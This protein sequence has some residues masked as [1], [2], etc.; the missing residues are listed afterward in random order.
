MSSTANDDAQTDR[1]SETDRRLN[2][3][4]V[5]RQ[6]VLRFVLAVLPV[7]ATAAALCMPLPNIWKA[8]WRSKLLDL[9]HIPLFALLTL[10]LYRSGRFGTWSA[11][12]LAVMVA[13]VGE[14]AQQAVH[15]SADVFDFLRGVTGAL[16]AI[17]WLRAFSRPPSVQR[18]CGSLAL[19]VALLVWPAADALPKMWDAYAAYRS[20]P[21]LCDFQSRWETTR[22][23]KNHMKMERVPDQHGSGRWLGRMDFYPNA[24]GNSGAVLFPVVRDWTNYRQLCCEFS[25]TG[26]PLYIL[27]SIR[28]GR[29][30]SEPLKRFDLVR[31]Y[32]AGGH[33][34]CID[35]RALARGDQ[36]APLDLSRVESFHFVVQHLGQ[37]RTINLRSVR[38][39]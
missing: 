25:F 11:L 32:T 33:Q 19:A 4:S 27:I 17:V 28:D 15:R 31:E 14:L 36:F 5:R 8:T 29:R 13:G 24:Q 12:G 39:E 7:V 23:V 1:A 6:T 22:W 38:L 9:G 20:F 18:L 21:V 30:V 16:L 26:E 35:L 2:G 3:S 37:P 34:V 10:C